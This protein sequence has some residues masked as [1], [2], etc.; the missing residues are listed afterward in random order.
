MT[1]RLVHELAADGVDVAVA[2]RVLGVSRSGYY[3]WAKRG[4]SAR[5]IDDAQSRADDPG[6]PT[7]TWRPPA[8][9]G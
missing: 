3:E 9:P 2:R 1:F 6:D 8:P 4:P 5:D 7:I